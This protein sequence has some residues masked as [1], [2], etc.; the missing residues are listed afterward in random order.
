NG[1]EYERIGAAILRATS[2]LKDIVASE[3]V[4]EAVDATRDLAGKVDADISK[5][6]DRYSETGEALRIYSAELRAA[7]E[8][9]ANPAAQIATLTTDLATAEYW[10]DRRQGD[11]DTAKF[12]GSAT[13]EELE[14]LRKDAV[15][16]NTHATNVANSL[17]YYQ[18]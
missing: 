11:Y 8:A 17:A 12:W 2:T 9:A 4:S 1:R 10:R 14:D 5:A 13:E 7:Q 3:Q 16:A 6:A 15:S 18:G